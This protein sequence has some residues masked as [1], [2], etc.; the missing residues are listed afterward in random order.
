MESHYTFAARSHE[1]GPEEEPEENRVT[2]SPSIAY[3]GSLYLYVEDNSDHA[4]V[5]VPRP[6]LVKFVDVAQAFLEETK[7]ALPTL[8]H[9]TIKAK[10][11][12]S[13]RDRVLTLVELD[14]REDG[15]VSNDGDQSA[16]WFSN[17]DIESFEVLFPGVEA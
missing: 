16:D 4:A 7:P 12:Y 3:P 8:P 15:W 6:E 9:A 1:E 14:R 11:K 5:H 10:M 17:D 2:V 13:D